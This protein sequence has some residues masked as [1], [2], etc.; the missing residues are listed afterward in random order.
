M[1]ATRITRRVAIA[2]A[3]FA[4]ATTACAGTATRAS[5][6]ECPV[7]GSTAEETEGLNAAT[8][9]MAQAVPTAE[10][11]PCLRNLPLGWNF[12]GVDIER[13]RA[14]YRLGASDPVGVGTVDVSLTATCEA[15]GTEARSPGDGIR[16]FID[17]ELS[18]P[19]TEPDFDGQYVGS[20]FF[21]GEG[22]CTEYRIRS[23]G[24]RV[25]ELEERLLAATGFVNRADLERLAPEIFG[26][27][28]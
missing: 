24:G 4:L 16:L 3:V 7:V 22:G 13:G 1:T 23:S 5:V 26:S 14:R 19:T 11:L 9:L 2:S 27:D 17:A 28:F 15:T 12:L 6:P 25:T 18:P 21:V 20:W 10:E 8:W